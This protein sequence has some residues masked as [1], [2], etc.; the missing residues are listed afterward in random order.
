MDD[1][2]VSYDIALRLRNLG[3]TDFCFGYYENKEFPVKVDCL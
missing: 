2:F 1:Q 3:F